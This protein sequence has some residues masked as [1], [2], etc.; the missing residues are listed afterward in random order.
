MS[1]LRGTIM[2]ML[3]ASPICAEETKH[4]VGA[5]RVPHH[6]APQ[7]ADG[8][9]DYGFSGVSATQPAE[10]PRLPALIPP[11]DDLLAYEAEEAMIE[12]EAALAADDGAE[13]SV[14][15]D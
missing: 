9:G 6:A 7:P 1:I 14:V 12:A 5:K 4:V 2:L 8:E 10:Q 3:F 13:T 11:D 15:I